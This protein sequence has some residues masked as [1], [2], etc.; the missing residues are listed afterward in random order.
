[1]EINRLGGTVK[2]FYLVNH[3]NRHKF[4]ENRH[5]LY[6]F[7][8]AKGET[9]ISCY[10]SL[11]RI[12]IMSLRTN[13]IYKSIY[14]YY[15]YI[16][17]AQRYTTFI[18]GYVFNIFGLLYTRVGAYTYTFY[19]T[20]T[21]RPANLFCAKIFSEQLRNIELSLRALHQYFMNWWDTSLSAF[22]QV[23]RYVQHKI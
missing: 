1:M 4:Y 13:F 22:S 15:F 7:V 21:C 19:T 12:K 14:L 16:I 9:L 5:L 23:I 3:C 11:V 6:R 18:P 8:S 20:I 10:I 2:D 17:M